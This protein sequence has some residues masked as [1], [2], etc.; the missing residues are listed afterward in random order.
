MNK[1]KIIMA[2]IG[3]GALVAAL[4]VGYLIYAANVE[5]GEIGE[6]FESLVSN[7]QRVNDGAIPPTEESIKALKDNAKALQ[8]WY[9]AAFEEVASGDLAVEP[10]IYRES[11]KQAMVDGARRLSKL[12]GE[13]EE[14]RLVKKNFNFGFP[15]ITTGTMPEQDKLA[16]YQRQ[17]AEVYHF[18]RMI[19]DAGAL[20]LQNVTVA[21][22]KAVVEETKPQRGGRRPN[23]KEQVEEKKPLDTV[24]TYTFK[25]TARPVALV[26]VVNALVAEERFTT[27]DALNFART[28]D[29]IATI[30]GG[31]K[32]KEAARKGRARAGRRVRGAE[33]G[34]EQTAEG[35]EKEANKKG[36]VTDPATGVPFTV[37]LT[38]STHDFGTGKKPYSSLRAV[39]RG[40]EE[41]EETA[42]E[43]P[44]AETPAEGAAVT[45]EKPAEAKAEEKPAAE[46]AQPAAEETKEVK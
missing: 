15:F 28:D 31:G 16:M 17:W 19:A 5:K 35:E 13:A 38:V 36:L 40:E 3:G 46:T 27:V 25:F 45:E 44:A 6:E 43:A 37:E 41:A 4:V 18:V 20:E 14:G 32:D 39:A 22:H 11:F 12:P 1:N 24:E 34:A 23:R 29:A 8:D 26:G 2:G 33:A 7:A 30:L 21:E 42:E 9:D 10:G